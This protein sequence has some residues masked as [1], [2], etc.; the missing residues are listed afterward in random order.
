MRRIISLIAA[1]AICL[2]SVCC[3]AAQSDMPDVYIDG[4]LL[5]MSHSA[6]IR[7]GQVYLPLVETFFAMG[8]Q[9]KYD[10]ES[11]K[12]IGN[13]NNGQIKAG[14]GEDVIYVDWVN[15]ALPSKIY[16]EADGTVMV[17]AYAVEDALK[18]EPYKYDSEK[19]RIDLVKPPFQ[20]AAQTFNLKDA[21][22]RLKGGT[23]ICG[24]EPLFN[25]SKDNGDSY[26]KME[27]VDVSNENM[28]FKRAIQLETLPL[29]NNQVPTSNYSIQKAAYNVGGDFEA[30]DVGVMTYWARA[31]KITDE[32]DTAGLRMCYER[33][34]D[35]HKLNINGLDGSVS[36]GKEWKQYIEV[37]CNDRYPIPNDRSRLCVG[38]GYKPQIVQVAGLEVI[39]YGKSVDLK[40]LDP[41]SGD[42]YNGIEP[43]ALWRKEANKRIEKLRKND[44]YISVKDESGNPIENVKVN[45]KLTKNEFIF[46][47]TVMRREYMNMDPDLKSTELQKN[48]YD[49]Y[50]NTIIDSYIKWENSCKNDGRESI[51]VANYTLTQWKKQVKAHANI[52]DKY[53]PPELEN[54]VDMSEDE[55]DRLFTEHTISNMWCFKGKTIQWDILNEPYDSK[56]YRS[57]HGD[58]V[59][60]NMIKT[61][62]KV[63]PITP[64]YV[65]ETGMEGKNKEEDQTREDGAARIV[66]A[67]IDAGAPI[68]G[69]GIQ[70]HCKNLN[71]PQGFYWQIDTYARSVKNLAVT[72]FDMYSLADTEVCRQYMEDLMRVTYSHPKAT[73]FLIWGHYD[74]NHWRA[75]S[76]FYNKDYVEKYGHE[77][78]R[79]LIMN[80][81]NTNESGKT[82]KEGLY[83]VRGHRGDYEITVEYNGKK[84]TVPF[85]LVSSQNDISDN[86]VDVVISK[87]GKITA[88]ATN[89]PKPLPE[90]IK[91][92]TLSEAYADFNARFDDDGNPIHIV[93]ADTD[94]GKDGVNVYDGSDKT[95]YVSVNDESSV[96]CELS[97]TAYSG[98]VTVTW[99]QDSAGTQHD[100][101]IY[102][103]DDKE[104]WRLVGEN[105]S[106]K[107]DTVGYENAKYIKI[108][109]QGGDGFGISE[110]TVDALKERKGK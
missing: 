87:N 73:G 40:S 79:K 106:R 34:G 51:Q 41:D 105:I 95:S 54:I 29:E 92:E 9:M 25:L 71:Y 16:A 6:A 102:V 72:E 97:D 32:T 4:K 109:Y 10:E 101:R 7:D 28:P 69:V 47:D 24:D 98:I 74:P 30:G 57:V 89:T 66:E 35:Y 42:T 5:R 90:P 22:R 48:F 49:D 33:S 83:T 100:Y 37:L 46:G 3:A 8:V 104:N 75:D 67:L 82:D 86:R 17:P 53:Y 26:I 110:I 81:W 84:Q 23:K 61:A 12:Y 70:A 94:S 21:V 39:N 76:N 62:K 56:V 59:F 68:D 78:F 27:T 13:G 50:L 38:I 64:L 80:E 19:N 85:T 1:I 2:S 96:I 20:K 60:V 36:V 77:V 103:S 14:V 45:A 93:N 65:N 31:V 63:D 99:K 52:W 107:N 11:G 88:T 44:M 18:T 15:V 58:N 91:F 55:V 43:D 108:E